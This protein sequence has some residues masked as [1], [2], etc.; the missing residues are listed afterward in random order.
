MFVCVAIVEGVERVSPQVEHVGEA[1][2]YA[3]KM[4][5]WAQARGVTLRSVRVQ[6]V[7]AAKAE[8]PATPTKGE[9]ACE[10]G[11]A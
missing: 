8:E 7:E 5:A 3:E 2:Q 10:G 1:K 9:R 4:F 6:R 11:A